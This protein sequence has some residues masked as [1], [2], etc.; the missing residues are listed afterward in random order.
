MSAFGKCEGPTWTFD[1]KNWVITIPHCV[2]GSN[3]LM[4]KFKGVQFDGD[5]QI[6]APDE[7]TCLVNLP[8]PLQCVVS[9]DGA[10]ITLT[11]PDKAE[12]VT[13]KV[14]AI[15]GAV[16]LDEDGVATEVPVEDCILQLPK[17][18]EICWGE[19]ENNCP[20]VGIKHCQTG[21]LL[22]LDQV[23]S[24]TG[25]VVDDSDP[26]NVI[27]EAVV[28]VTGP[29]VDTTD[30][31]NPVVNQSNFDY[32]PETG[33]ITH[34][35]A[36]GT[37][38]TADTKH[39]TTEPVV[40]GF[41]DI[42]TDDGVTTRVCLTPIKTVNGV[43][44]DINGNVNAADLFSTTVDNG[45]GTFTTTNPDGVL[46]TWSGDT[47]ASQMDNGNG[48][49]TF[50]MADGSTVTLCLNPVKDIRENAD[51]SH[52]VVYADGTDGV[53]IPG[54]DGTASQG[55][56]GTNTIDGD[57][58]P[59]PVGTPVI[60]FYD[61]AGNYVNSCTKSSPDCYIY[62]DLCNPAGIRLVAKI[63]VDDDAA[64]PT[65]YNTDG[66]EFTGDLAGFNVCP[67]QTLANCD[68]VT[69]PSGSYNVETIDELGASNR[70]YWMDFDDIDSGD[71]C[72]PA[73]RTGCLKA[74]AV[75]QNPS[76]QLFKSRA[77]SSIWRMCEVAC[78]AFQTSIN[79]GPT[80][81]VREDSGLP[82]AP[83]GGRLDVRE[84]LGA[85]TVLNNDC[86]RSAQVSIDT[87][88]RLRLDRRKEFDAGTATIGTGADFQVAVNGGAYNA[89]MSTFLGEYR[90]GEQTGTQDWKAS[91]TKVIVPPKGA[92]VI[93][94]KLT[95]TSNA[96][97]G[98]EH[99]FQI[100]Y[101][102]PGFCAEVN[103]K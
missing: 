51:G 57:G 70:G 73:A 12:P 45:D 61:G 17:P 37:P 99:I 79:L 56:A 63:N 88:G 65:Y 62:V 7:E 26:K 46:V 81:I 11:S 93:D 31:Q 66:S 9:E 49:V 85:F 25:N 59:V 34:T 13:L 30:P 86:C 54:N 64:A 39:S 98:D 19:D 8:A 24:V 90:L 32:D 42:T 48:T 102:E 41:H 50:T 28:S 2:D 83:T 16:M 60:N 72:T 103:Y 1:G 5:P 76:G 23:Q 10:T 40:A 27:I 89:V 18:E 77:N 6:Y 33:V 69:R 91:N 35:A 43:A 68:G 100:L 44:P 22:V 80:V 53:T 38:V 52:T 94:W 67:V 92:A 4:P 75:T 55:I 97:A 29:G 47:F 74:P 78:E 95:Y 84:E 101:N 82:P 36:D 71:G 3:L 58:N 14:Q 87:F 21:E 96:P 20:V 15:T